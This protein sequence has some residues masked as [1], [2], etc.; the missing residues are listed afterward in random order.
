M[1]RPHLGNWEPGKHN[2]AMAII[3]LV[4]A[5]QAGLR[6]LDYIKNRPGP[7][8]P[9]V[10][11]VEQI[12]SLHL[13]GLIFLAGAAVLVTSLS[14]GWIVGVFT[15]HALLSCAYIVLGCILLSGVQQ[16]SLLS[17]VFGSVLLCVGL[18]LSLGRWQQCNGLR[19]TSS[20][21]LMVGGGWWA[22]AGLGVDFRS[23]TGVI[24]AGVLQICLLLG[25]AVFVYRDREVAE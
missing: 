20:V 10:R 13:W 7:L 15:G 16:T 22:G 18:W 11:A 17:A 3:Q 25:T 8:S 1:R 23:A 12:G 5:G 14:G 9:S 24:S 2:L 4:A 6:G 19:F 21:V